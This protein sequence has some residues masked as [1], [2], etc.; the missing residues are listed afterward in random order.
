MLGPQFQVSYSPV[1]RPD[2]RETTTLQGCIRHT[3]VFCR[4]PPPPRRCSLVG[5]CVVVRCPIS[6]SHAVMRPSTLSLPAAIADKLSSTATATTVVELTCRWQRKRNDLLVDKA[7]TKMCYYSSGGALVASRCLPL[8]RLRWL[9]VAF[10][11]KQ[12]EQRTPPAANQR[13]HH[14]VYVYVSRQLGLI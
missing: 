5:C 12:K 4:L 13:Q 7:G 1:S 2:F 8:Q 11:A 14:L 6:S 3:V 9:V 10:Y